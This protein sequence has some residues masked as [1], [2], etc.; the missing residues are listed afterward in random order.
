MTTENKINLGDDLKAKQLELLERFK[1]KKI[2]AFL[3]EK[4][5]KGLNASTAQTAV[6]DGLLKGF[7]FEDFLL[8]NVY[9]VP[10]GGSYSL[11][12]S[13]GNI[14]KRANALGHCG[15]TAPIYEMRDDEK[16]IKSCSISVKR[17]LPNGLIGE[18][19][20]T[21]FFDEYTTNRNLWLS[22]PATMIAKVAE[23]SAL[24]KAFS[25]EMSDTYIEEEFQN[26]SER[27]A[28]LTEISKVKENDK[29]NVDIYIKQIEKTNTFEEVE[30]LENKLKGFNLESDEI[31]L[32]ANAINVQKA[33][34]QES[35]DVIK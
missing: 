16:R 21:V 4:I 33:Q 31:E 34:I 15:T 35:I 17:I 28:K 25:G 9:A 1:D 30:K 22:K 24:R 14:R 18:Y 13:I 32:L 19:F 29:I 10:L 7:T 8:K 5:F 20:S 27:D 6:L 2:E 3:L 26:K 23:M 12:E 11:V